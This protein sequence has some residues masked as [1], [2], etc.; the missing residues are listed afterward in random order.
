M[1][2]LLDFLQEHWVMGLATCGSQGPHSAPVF[3]A[4]LTDPLRLIFVSEPDT[5]HMREIAV[6]PRV[7]AAIWQE[8]RE[9]G[10]IR[11]AQCWGRVEMPSDSSE[12]SQ[13]YLE[14]FP[15]A[16][17]VLLASAKH[18]FCALH[19]ERVRFINKRLGMGKNQEWKLP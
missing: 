13:A 7:A 16:R 14:K 5:R 15:E 19:V 17:L 3:Y 4:V 18:R 12:L 9:P 1:K 11:G 2:P 10:R 8:T 6:D